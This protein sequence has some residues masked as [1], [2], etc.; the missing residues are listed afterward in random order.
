MNYKILTTQEKI[1][2]LRNQ[3]LTITNIC[4]HLGVGKGTVG[5][6][7]KQL[8]LNKIKKP[9]IVIRKK[10][11]QINDDHKQI[12]NNLR[13]QKISYDEIAKII[14]CTRSTVYKYINENNICRKD[15]TP[16]EKS[17]RKSLHVINWKKEKKKLLIEY[18]GGK[19]EKC[20]YD[21]CIEALEFHHLDPKQKDFNVS[22]HSFSFDR[23]KKEAD[24]C[25]LVCSNCHREIHYNEK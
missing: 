9:V 2:Y 13:Q 12:I 23:M 17:R 1:K 25:I 16:K 6:H 14:G 8:G 4:K 5:Y 10:Y 18:K 24:K 22:S 21:K 11:I 7:L 20:G 3:G 19:C 15:E